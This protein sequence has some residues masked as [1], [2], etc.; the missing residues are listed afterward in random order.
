MAHDSRLRKSNIRTALVFLSV[1]LVFFAGVFV[2]RFVG[3][4]D[5]ALAVLGVAMLVF[6]VVA[7][8]RNL[9]SRE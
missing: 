9:R 8:A 2:A 1:A 5:G 3:T 4:T 6:L 7:V